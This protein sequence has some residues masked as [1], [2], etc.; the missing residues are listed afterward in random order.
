MRTLLRMR[1][2]R[3]TAD[4][5][6]R[7]IPSIDL[8]PPGRSEALRRLGTLDRRLGIR[9][10]LGL[11]LIVFAVLSR[12]FMTQDTAN[13]AET[14]RVAGRTAAMEGLTADV[15]RV[16]ETIAAETLSRRVT[17]LDA[18]ALT[19][20]SPRVVDALADVLNARVDGVVV[21][22]AETTGGAE[23]TVRIDAR[24]NFVVLTWRARINES[25]AVARVVSVRPVGST[26]PT[27]YVATILVA[28]E[29]GR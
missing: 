29:A 10:G 6:Y 25:P 12:N 26:A 14:D 27:Q 21:R 23:V 13:L 5:F 20:G 28:R 8:L 11:V 3:T 15:T 2:A 22:A 18:A 7:N 17:A 4:A 16:Q 24:D 19:P 9:V 1:R